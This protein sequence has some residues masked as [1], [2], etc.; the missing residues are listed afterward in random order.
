MRARTQARPVSRKKKNQ[1]EPATAI[2]TGAKTFPAVN[3][4]QQHKNGPVAQLYRTHDAHEVSDG[5]ELNSHHIQK[6]SDF[7]RS[8]YNTSVTFSSET[9]NFTGEKTRVGD[10]NVTPVMTPNLPNLKISETDQMAVV[11]DGA[12]QRE[13]FATQQLFD[14]SNQML[15]G[16]AAK[17]RLGKEGGNLQLVDNGPQLF[18]IVPLSQPIPQGNWTK[19]ESISSTFCNKVTDALIGA[20]ARVGVLSKAKPLQQDREETEVPMKQK[21]NDPLWLREFLAQQDQ[22]KP[23]FDQLGPTYE[24]YFHEDDE[25]LE[26]A[27]EDRGN[28]DGN[29]LSQESQ[30]YGLNE[31]ALPEPGE[32]YMT[33][34]IGT[35]EYREHAPKGI[36]RA[37]YF[38]LLQE[39][40]ALNPALDIARQN[41][42]EKAKTL[43][44]SWSYHFAT[45]V[46]R[47]GADTMT[48][49]NY[50]RGVENENH[51]RDIFHKLFIGF[52]EFREEVQQKLEGGQE[53][54]GNIRYGANH[55]HELIRWMAT[56]LPVMRDDLSQNAKTAL[57]EALYSIETGLNVST[58]YNQEQLYFEMYGSGNQSLHTKFKNTGYNPNTLRVRETH[59]IE[60]KKYI[61]QLAAAE[62]AAIQVFTATQWDKSEST[63][64]LKT[65]LGQ[66]IFSKIGQC[67]N[68]L[69]G[70]KNNKE[71]NQ[72]KE[73]RLAE[74]NGLKLDNLDLNF[75]VLQLMKKYV[76]FT[77]IFNPGSAAALYQTLDIINNLNRDNTFTTFE[78]TL[79]EHYGNQVDLTTYNIKSKTAKADLAKIPAF[80][81]QILQI[82]NQHI[83]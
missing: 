78:S 26:Q 14:T 32:A 31:F 49:E 41:M 52:E 39:L 21:H 37:E 44:D 19:L 45:V 58:Q 27:V 70:V 10:G 76:P 25:R 65:F 9:G 74:L 34:S 33:T 4:V 22:D 71:M 42:S 13:F 6:D 80:R 66:E 23:P 2:N 63:S 53:V 47:D 82:F 60:Q 77:N 67:R 68:K 30:K 18:R 43:I 3:P 8:Y 62:N 48:L 79:R 57:Q 69:E 7:S 11:N 72:W 51:I 24:N 20:T 64:M 75:A 29:L 12:Q 54:D 73:T 83:N 56:E 61:H 59:Q 36:P 5:L 40:Q 38:G 55:Y 17:V 16:S 81:Q 46:A 15:E 28:I 50:N 35:P 1:E